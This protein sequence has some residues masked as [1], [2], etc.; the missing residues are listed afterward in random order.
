MTDGFELEKSGGDKNTSVAHI[1]PYLIVAVIMFVLLSLVLRF[2]FVAALIVT[3][4]FVGL[5]KI[6]VML[7]T[8]KTGEGVESPAKS[9]LSI[10]I[11][12]IIAI[13]GI[14]LLLPVLAVLFCF[15]LSMAAGIH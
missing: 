2:S 6:V 12:I 15:F 5:S 13:G 9:T 11:M 1:Y 10:F 3:V 4:F 8:K 7:R 14:F